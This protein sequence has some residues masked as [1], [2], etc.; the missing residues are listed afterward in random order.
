LRGL[1]LGR[2]VGF[3]AVA[4]ATTIRHMM[5]N[6]MGRICV[7]VVLLSNV[8]KVFSLIQADSAMDY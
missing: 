1:A 5:L 2:L 3:A 7:M 4:L 8:Q 6:T